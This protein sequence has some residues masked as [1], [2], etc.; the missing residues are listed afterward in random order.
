MNKL[1][2]FLFFVF[3][4]SSTLAFTQVVLAP[5]ETLNAQ[6]GAA[7]PVPPP[8][9]GQSPPIE[10]TII[11]EVARQIEDLEFAIAYIE[12]IQHYLLI[13]NSGH[14]VPDVRNGDVSNCSCGNKC[15]NALLKSDYNGYLLHLMEVLGVDKQHAEKRLADIVEKRK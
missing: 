12:C 3:L 14:P 7:I 5:L 4:L 2:S 15:R 6:P 11:Q 13:P 9:I 8:M 10:S 1:G